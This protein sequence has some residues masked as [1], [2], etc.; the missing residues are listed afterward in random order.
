MAIWVIVGASRGVGLELVRQLLAKGDQ[1]LA[2]VRDPMNASQLWALAGSAGGRCRLY[3]CDVATET[4]IVVR[5]ASG[6][7]SS[8]IVSSDLTAGRSLSMIYLP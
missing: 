6:A 8:P 7:V 4:S 5:I 3:E 1:V 2:S